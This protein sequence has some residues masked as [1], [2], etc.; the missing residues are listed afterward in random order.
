MVVE[1]KVANELFPLN[2]DVS[3]VLLHPKVFQDVVFIFYLKRNS[4]KENMCNFN[5]YILKKKQF[6]PYFFETI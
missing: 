6:L 4:V 3:I 1:I 2:L 5:I